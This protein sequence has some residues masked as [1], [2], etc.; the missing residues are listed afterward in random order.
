[1]YIDI[2][3]PAKLLH[4]FLRCNKSN[5]NQYEGGGGERTGGRKKRRKRERMSENERE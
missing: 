5:I 4:Y 3:V 2:E 1:M